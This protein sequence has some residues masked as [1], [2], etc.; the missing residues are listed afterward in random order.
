MNASGGESRC[1]AVENRAIVISHRCRAV[2]SGRR[3]GST[4][5][6]HVAGKKAEASPTPPRATQKDALHV[7]SRGH[8]ARREVGLRCREGQAKEVGKSSW[9]VPD[10]ARRAKVR[11]SPRDE[12][13]DAA[14]SWDC[15]GPAVYSASWMSPGQA[16]LG[17]RLERCSTCVAIWPARLPGT[18]KRSPRR[19]MLTSSAVSIWRRF[20]S[21]APHRLAR[22]WL[23]TGV[24]AISTGF[25]RVPVPVRRAASAAW[26]R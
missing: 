13:R 9:Q 26:R 23:L 15:A 6:R 19:A 20:S 12:R 24:K 10:L 4:C 25:K 2:D 14:G 16:G 7:R 3:Y 18:A 17:G 5:G 8:R 1:A 22:R 11:F 21:S